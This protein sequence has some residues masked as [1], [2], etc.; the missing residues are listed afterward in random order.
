MVVAGLPCAHTGVAMA[1]CEASSAGLS[2]TFKEIHK[3][4]EPSSPVL[5]LVLHFYLLVPVS[6]PVSIVCDH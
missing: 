5:S 4:P 3:Y 2:R 6:A 1:L